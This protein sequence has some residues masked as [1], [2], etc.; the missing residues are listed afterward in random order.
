MLTDSKVR[1]AKPREKSY[2]VYDG[3][4]LYLEVPPKGN[5]RWRWRYKFDGKE[6]RMS[7]GVYPATTLKAA[8]LL[9]DKQKERLLMGAKPTLKDA[10]ADTFRAV[11]AS[12][13]AANTQRWSPRHTS[14]ITSRLDNHVL[15]YIGDRSIKAL[16]PPDFLALV[17]R[18]ERS[19]AMEA[20]RRTLQICSQIC[21]YAVAHFL[22]PSDPCRDLRGALV[23]T[24]KRHFPTLDDKDEIGKLMLAIDGY[25]GAFIV[26]ALMQFQA[27]T[28][29]RPSEAR[30]AR[31]EEI[32]LGEE[33]WIIPASRMK[34]RRDHIVP[35]S[36]QALR[37]LDS[38]KA[39]G[40]RSPLLFPAIRTPNGERPLSGNTVLMALR[41]MG[42]PKEVL[43]THSFR[44]MA[45]TMLNE[46][47][48]NPDVIEKQL[49]HEPGNAVR[50]VYNRA[51]WMVERR[52]LMQ[53]WADCL[54][55]WREAAR[56]AL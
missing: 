19:G 49:A 27:L 16:T 38:L 32:K 54:D 1:A 21:R 29:V 17:Q 48:C 39:V 10:D 24:R 46:L 26:K 25:P 51:Q 30:L 34:M 4:G 45:S 5:P 7:L 52:E 31:W 56:A 40:Y 13:L 47:G 18:V 20:A 43:V 42:Y 15:P 8:R 12:W 37:L 3:E 44:S 14:T 23:Q 53:K 6:N 9:R 50:A 22:L 36:R 11:A 35:L 55:A 33:L 28:F 2:K 41:L